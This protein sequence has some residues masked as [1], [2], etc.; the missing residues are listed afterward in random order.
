MWLVSTRILSY[1]TSGECD[2]SRLSIT[3][4]F[5]L[6]GHLS[7]LTV[8]HLTQQTAIHEVHDMT[9]VTSVRFCILMSNPVNRVSDCTLPRAHYSHTLR[10][11]LRSPDVDHSMRTSSTHTQPGVPTAPHEPAPGAATA[12]EMTKSDRCPPSRKNAAARLS[13]RHIH[14]HIRVAYQGA[15]FFR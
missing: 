9:L 14:G 7:V 13:W 15:A 11:T 4:S 6:A 1:Q 3:W 8:G 5:R 10:Q 2:P 12:H